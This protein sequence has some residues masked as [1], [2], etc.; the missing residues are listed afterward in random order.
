MNTKTRSCHQKPFQKLKFSNVY[1]LP[2]MSYLYMY[3]FSRLKIFIIHQNDKKMTKTNTRNWKTYKILLLCRLSDSGSGGRISW[4]R[5]LNFSGGRHFN[6]EVEIPNNDSISWSRHFSW[7]RNCLIML[8]RVLISWSKCLPPDWHCEI[9]M[10]KFD[11]MNKFNFNLMKKWISI[12]WNLTSWSIPD[13][14]P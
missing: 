10:N 4:D 8:F 13:F 2:V 11:L 9:L 5:N 7:D 3:Y 1:F 12:S 6:H 14:R